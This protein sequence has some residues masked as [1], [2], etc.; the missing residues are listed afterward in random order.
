MNT[1]SM[2]RKKKDKTPN[3]QLA[4]AI[5]DQY[6][7]QSVEDMQNA[8]KDIF[9]PMFEA[10][11]QGEMNSHLGYSNNER[12]EKETVSRR[13]GYTK[14][15]LKTTVGDVP[16]EVPRDREG[17]FEPVVVPKRKR[18]VSAIQDKVL[19]MY[20]KGMSQRDLAETIE[21]IYGFEISHETIS[22]ITD[23]V[24]E[25][26]EE[27]QNRPLKKFYTF[28]FVDCLYVTIRKDY[29]TKNCAVCVILG[30]DVDGQK[31]ILGLWLGESESRHQWM[32][33]FDEIK[34]RGV[35]DVLFISMDGVSGLEEGAKAISP[36]GTVQR[37][38]VHLIRNSIKYVPNKDYKEFTAQLKKVYGAASLKAAEAEF[39][40]FKQAW[41]QYPGAVDVWVRNWQH[42]AQLYDYG[43]AI[44]KI[45]YMTNAVESVNSSLRKVTKKGAFPNENALFKLLYLRITE[46]YK[47]WN[48][49]PLNNWALVRN[50]LDM[51]KKSK[52]ESV[53]MKMV[54][55]KNQR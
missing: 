16:I 49:R 10:M 9:G 52:N 6:Q 15:T 37:C 39:E 42:A 32:Q 43:S 20:A 2:A 36:N 3:Q 54:D 40:R 24:L 22:G 30:Y 18:D 23:S 13:N 1:L 45:L 25:Q 47:K 27:W 31:D 14:K 28:L 29:E 34:S 26:L 8:L 11:L 44:R 48:G 50:Q 55:C 38:I 21:D 53:N 33:I 19:S 12:G 4:Q 7:P 35:E 5:I 46:L 17:T 51:D 41:S